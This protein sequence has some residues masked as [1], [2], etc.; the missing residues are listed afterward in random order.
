MVEE[1]DQAFTIKDLSKYLRIAESSLY[2][3]VREGKIPGQ[4]IGKTWRFFK[5]A[6]DSWLSEKSENRENTGKGK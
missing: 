4:K 6:I 5:P 2:K 1:N 3:L